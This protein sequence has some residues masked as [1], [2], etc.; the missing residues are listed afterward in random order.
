MVPFF[1]YTLKSINRSNLAKIT[2]FTPPVYHKKK[3]DR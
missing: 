1:A 2:F 3:I